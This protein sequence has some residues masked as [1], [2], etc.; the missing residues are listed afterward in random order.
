MANAV[1]VW[2]YRLWR[3]CPPSA[4]A[5]TAPVRPARSAPPTSA[6]PARSHLHRAVLAD[7]DQVERHRRVLHPEADR[8]RSPRTRT[9]CRDR[10]PSPARN[11]SPRS[12]SPRI[13]GD[14]DGEG[15]LACVGLDDQRLRVDRQHHRLAVARRPAIRKRRNR[16]Q[17]R[18]DRDRQSHLPPA[19]ICAASEYPGQPAARL[20]CETGKVPISG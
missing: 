9:A 7:E 6:R 14:L 11:I 19:R 5:R 15:A 10:R 8:L 17:R 3:R 12:R 4:R 20:Q 1:A 18:D 2:R 13:V 16:R